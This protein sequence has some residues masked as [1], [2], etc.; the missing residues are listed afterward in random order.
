MR[1]GLDEKDLTILRMMQEDGRVSYS[2][3][4]RKLG[5]SE[6]AVY[7]RVKKL[8]RSGYIKRFQAILNEEKMGYP[9]TAFIAIRAEPSKY[10]QVLKKLTRFEEMQ[11]IHDITGD[12]SCLLK[13]RAKDKDHLTHILDEIG[14]I[15][16]VVATET[17]IV[18]RTIKETS[19][20]PIKVKPH[21]HRK[22]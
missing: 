7:T 4:A 20:I 19:F 1:L 14:K 17:R 12:Y 16:G 11:E 8:V 5:I 18:L 22:T 13:L 21:E 2:E 9:L 6:A 3:M 10:D 15:D